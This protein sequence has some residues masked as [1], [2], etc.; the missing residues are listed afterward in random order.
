MAFA[1]R[2]EPGVPDIRLLG[3]HP[4]T[5]RPLVPAGQETAPLFTGVPSFHSDRFIS[6]Y[7]LERERGKKQQPNVEFHPRFIR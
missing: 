2:E 7:I 4:K 6:K 5:G 3:S 1:K